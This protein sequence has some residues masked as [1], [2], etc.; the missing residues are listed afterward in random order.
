MLSGPFPNK[1]HGMTGERTAQYAQ[2][3]QVKDSLML[4]IQSMEMR[5]VVIPPEHL[6][7]NTIEDADR[8][9]V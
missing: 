4:S 3:P 1:R 9:H 8:R 7:H 5:W 2:I 6:N